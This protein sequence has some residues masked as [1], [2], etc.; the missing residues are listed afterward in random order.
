MNN[1]EILTIFHKN[2]NIL[3]NK[4]KYSRE[5]EDEDHE[6]AIYALELALDNPSLSATTLSEIIAGERAG[7]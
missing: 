1:Q 6:K 3:R 2:L 5:I 7:K 4:G